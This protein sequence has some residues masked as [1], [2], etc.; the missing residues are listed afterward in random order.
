[1]MIVWTRK[2]AHVKW[3]KLHYRSKFESSKKEENDDLKNCN[4]LDHVHVHYHVSILMAMVNEKFFSE[5]SAVAIAHDHEIEKL[6]VILSH[7]DHVKLKTNPM[8]VEVEEA[9]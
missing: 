5:K 9:F 3:K 6:L 8:M 1:M 2:N 7:D 4:D